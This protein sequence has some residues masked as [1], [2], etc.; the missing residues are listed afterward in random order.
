MCA[1]VRTSILILIISTRE[2]AGGGKSNF[3]QKERNTQNPISQ[4]INNKFSFSLSLV[5]SVSGFQNI[6]LFYI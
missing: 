6:V 4:I 3:T 1:C 5:L 2:W